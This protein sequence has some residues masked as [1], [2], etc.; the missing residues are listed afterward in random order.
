MSYTQRHSQDRHRRIRL[1]RHQH[2]RKVVEEQ[3]N[4]DKVTLENKVQQGLEPGHVIAN[5]SCRGVRQLIRLEAV[6]DKPVGYL[7]SIFDRE[8]ILCTKFWMP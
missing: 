8:T 6:P 7:D 2:Y 1:R 5:A 4:R 3:S